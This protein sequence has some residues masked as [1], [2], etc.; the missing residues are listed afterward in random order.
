MNHIKLIL[1]FMRKKKNVQKMPRKKLMKR[2]KVGDMPYAI[3]AF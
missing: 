1:K 3:V 2:N